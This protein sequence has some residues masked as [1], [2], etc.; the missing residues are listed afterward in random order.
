MPPRNQSKLDPNLSPKSYTVCSLC[1]LH[2]DHPPT[3]YHS[4]TTW[5]QQLQHTTMPKLISHLTGSQWETTGPSTPT[6]RFLAQYIATVDSKGYNTGSGLKFYSKDVTFHNQNNAVY[7][8]GE[9]MWAWMKKLFAAF[10][11]IRHD[12]VHLVEIERDDGSSQVYCQ[13]VRNL[14]MLGSEGEEPDVRIPVTMIAI[15][16][17]SGSEG[18]PEG[19][20]FREVWLYWDTA[21]LSPFLAKDAVV[22]RR[23]NV[24]RAD[25]VEA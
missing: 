14:W 22:F 17:R 12:W 3:C 9:E 25:E 4:S 2:S 21:L 10:E 19:L 1:L 20:C 18:T 24:L 8:G 5:R 15:V 23:E 6:Q 7:H 16:G 11:R 13:N